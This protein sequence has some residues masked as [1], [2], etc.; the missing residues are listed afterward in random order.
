MVEPFWG[1]KGMLIYM[2]LTESNEKQKNLE[3]LQGKG[4]MVIGFVKRDLFS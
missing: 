3:N 4:V 2:V 1:K